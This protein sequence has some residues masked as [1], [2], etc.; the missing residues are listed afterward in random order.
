[1]PDTG[2]R[3]GKHRFDGGFDSGEVES[4]TGAFRIK[5]PSHPSPGPL[6]LICRR[7]WSGPGYTAAD[8]RFDVRLPGQADFRDYGGVRHHRAQPE[9]RFPGAARAPA[10]ATWL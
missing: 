1:M 4:S 9:N 8:Y 7:T 5:A 3:E 2:E 6:D 10:P